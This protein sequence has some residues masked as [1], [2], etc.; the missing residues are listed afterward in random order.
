MRTITMMTAAFFLFAPSLANAAAITCSQ[1]PDA[2]SYVD[3]LQPGPNTQRA[4]QH[5]DAAK[6]ATS[7]RACVAQLRQANIYA[8][9]SAAADRRMA[10]RGHA[11]VRCA[12]ALHEDRPG[13]TDYH[14]SSPTSCPRSRI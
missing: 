11:P 8:K 4:Q 6:Q 14:G 12:D 10:S 13:G 9:R 1:I 2:Q 3:K 5:I 7:E